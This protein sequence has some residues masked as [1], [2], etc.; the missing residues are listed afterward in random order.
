M[1]LALGPLLYY[2]PRQQVFDFYDAIASAP[3]DIVYLGEGITPIVEAAP[4]L[5]DQVGVSFAYKNDGQNPSASSKKSLTSSA[6]APSKNSGLAVTM[7]S[8]SLTASLR[9][10]RVPL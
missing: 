7:P 4:A 10:L 8:T 5:R 6:L 9:T 2:W 1:K 3:V